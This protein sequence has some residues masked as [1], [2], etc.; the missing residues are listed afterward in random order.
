MYA[1]DNGILQDHICRN[2]FFIVDGIIAGDKNGPMEPNSVNAGI[3]AFGYNALNVDMAL[4][5]FIGIDSNNIPLYQIAQEHTNG[6]SPNG[7]GKISVN[8]KEISNIKFEDKFTPPDNW[9]F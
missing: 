7:Y 3:V 1:D 6:L 5:K 4:L 2:H 9:K 8:G